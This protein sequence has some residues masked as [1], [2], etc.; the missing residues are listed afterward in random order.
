[1]QGLSLKIKALVLFVMGIG[2]LTLTSLGV[3]YYQS[4]ALV[5]V[6]TNDERELNFRDE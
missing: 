1:M 5:S 3:T 2:M 4:K 6:Q